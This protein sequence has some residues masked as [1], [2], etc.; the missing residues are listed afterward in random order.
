MSFNQLQTIPCELTLKG[1][2]HGPQL[3]W[4]PVKEFEALRAS[5][6]QIAQDFDF[7]D[8]DRYR[9]DILKGDLQEIRATFRP[10]KDCRV[11]FFI[12]GVEVVYDAGK[13]EI[14]IGNHHAAAPLID[15]EQKLIMVIDRTML[16]IWASDGLTYIPWPVIPAE[17]E[18]HAEFT[19]QGGSMRA[20]RLDRYTLK[21]IWDK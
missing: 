1:M 10:E 16:T 14:V 2:A 4:Q 5:S 12:R 3:R 9:F 13:Q 17:R 11:V 19:I 8:G 21:S 20:S 6:S 18:V 15:G 7:K